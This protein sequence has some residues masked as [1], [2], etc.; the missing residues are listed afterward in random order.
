MSSAQLGI[1]QIGVSYPDNTFGDEDF[2][3]I[4][5]IVLSFLF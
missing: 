4:P 3:G 2:F 1:S 5:F